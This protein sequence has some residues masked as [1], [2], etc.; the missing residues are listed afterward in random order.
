MFLVNIFIIK[1]LFL[2]VFN[3]EIMVNNDWILVVKYI[4]VSYEKG[5]VLILRFFI[6]NILNYLIF[7]KICVKIWIR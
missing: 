6:E 5:E 4:V 3:K 2:I 1:R 7:L